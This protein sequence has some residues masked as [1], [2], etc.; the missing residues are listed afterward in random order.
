MQ[1]K[2]ELRSRQ[3]RVGGTKKIL[4]DRLLLHESGGL[5]A[6][7]V[8]TVEMPNAVVANLGVEVPDKFIYITCKANVEK[9]VKNEVIDKYGFRF[10]FSRPGLL[11]FKV[12][13]SSNDNIDIDDI[14]TIF[15]SCQGC[16]ISSVDASGYNEIVSIAKSLKLKHACD[17]IRLHVYGRDEGGAKV[18]HPEY[19][20][21]REKRALQIVH[22]VMCQ[23]GATGAFYSNGDVA[24]DGDVV[25]DVIF[26]PSDDTEKLFIG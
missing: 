9:I 19:I 26:G 17:K 16:S 6:P 15:G 12:D 7:N 20:A 5:N 3:L 10:A 14:V 24:R 8:E 2:E 18:E 4:I 25:L 13:E 23:E 11:T 1:L 22:G 21:K